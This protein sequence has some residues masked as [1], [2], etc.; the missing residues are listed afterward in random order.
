MSTRR[1][2]QRDLGM[3]EDMVGLD[4]CMGNMDTDM[5]YVDLNF[6]AYWIPEG[7]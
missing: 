2:A 1:S 5:S 7:L 6:G 3:A 4:E